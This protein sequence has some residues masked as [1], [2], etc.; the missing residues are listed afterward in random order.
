MKCTDARAKATKG[1]SGYNCGV[2]RVGKGEEEKKS[3]LEGGEEMGAS[4]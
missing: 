1:V 3:Q 2:V 4:H